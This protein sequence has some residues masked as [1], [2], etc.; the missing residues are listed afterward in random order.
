[1]ILYSK[2]TGAFFFSSSLFNE[3]ELIQYNWQWA[4]VFTEDRQGGG[5]STSCFLILLPSGG[6]LGCGSAGRASFPVIG[7]SLVWFSGS[8]GCMSKDPL[9]R[10]GTPDCSRLAVG[11]FHSSLFHQFVNVWMWQVFKR[12][13][14]SYRSAGPFMCW[15]KE[16]IYIFLTW[17]VDIMCLIPPPDMVLTIWIIFYFGSVS[18]SVH[19]RCMT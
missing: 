19:P 8:P 4:A 13:E 1:M 14:K 7:R 18:Y 9:A 5:M 3:T 12:M 17:I 15:R 16:C 2:I 10:Y 6:L 11:T